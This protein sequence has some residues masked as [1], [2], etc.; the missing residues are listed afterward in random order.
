MPYRAGSSPGQKFE[1]VWIQEVVGNDRGVVGK[2]R[3]S[4]EAPGWR[5]V[6][7]SCRMEGEKSVPRGRA[8]GFRLGRNQI[9]FPL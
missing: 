5:W 7:G 9:E 2:A 3:W 1:Y 8:Q 4:G 6:S